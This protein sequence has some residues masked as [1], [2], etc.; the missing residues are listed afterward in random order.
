MLTSLVDYA[1][2]S[3]G[4]FVSSINALTPCMKCVLHQMEN[5][6]V[7][8][9]SDRYSCYLTWTSQPQVISG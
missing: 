6:T 9:F 7:D 3:Y 1:E 2:D 8:E 5:L 4:Y